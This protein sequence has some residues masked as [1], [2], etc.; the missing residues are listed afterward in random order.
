M[1]T[2]SSACAELHAHPT[3]SPPRYQSETTSGYGRGNDVHQSRSPTWTL[4]RGF[5][6]A[7]DRRTRSC[8]T[9]RSPGPEDAR[10]EYMVGSV[11]RLGDA[12]WNEEE[13]APKGSLFR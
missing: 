7:H 8:M 5:S 4:T 13:G 11:A 1:C 10:H 6:R 9:R 3:R 2:S 12:S